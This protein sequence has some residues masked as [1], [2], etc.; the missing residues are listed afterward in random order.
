MPTPPAQRVCL[1]NVEIKAELRDIELARSVCRSIG[2]KHIGTLIQTDT[3]FRIPQGRFKR[4]VT[5]G[6]PTEYIFYDRPDRSRPKLSHFSLYSEAEAAS[7]YGSS[8]MPELCV[9]H[10][11][12]DLYMYN[13]T[14]VHLDQ[15][16]DLGTFIEF[17]AMVSPTNNVAR[18]HAEIASLRSS[19]EIVMGE[20]IA[21]S[22]ADLLLQSAGESTH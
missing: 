3:Y 18:C 14:R 2:A 16:R 20:P 5:Q 1:L 10:K 9:V 22:Y 11:Q 7:R 6:E 21:C 15:V 19:F 17:E 8:P 13:N 12:R 4:R